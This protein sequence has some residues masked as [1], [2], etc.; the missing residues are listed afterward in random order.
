MGNKKFIL[1]ADNFGVNN[2]IN[3]GVLD[4]YNAGLIT[5]AGICAN[6]KEFDAAV[7][8]I[9]PECPHLG[10]CAN[11][12]ISFGN[13]I[14]NC[15]FIADGRRK[16]NNT[17]AS[18]YSMS[19][20]KKGI[21]AIEKEF[22][23]QIEKISEIKKIDALNSNGNVHAIPRIFNIVCKL[24]SEY[25]IPFVRLSREEIIIPHEFGKVTKLRFSVNLIKT[26]I[27]N[28]FS[29]ENLKTAEKYGIKTNNLTIGTL[30]R[31]FLEPQLVEEYLNNIQGDCIVECFVIPDKVNRKKEYNLCQ[32]KLLADKIFRCGFDLTNYRNLNEK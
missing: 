2:G 19:A 17:Y 16:F 32:N 9:L 7:N 3:R 12:N 29:K 24:A 23:A 4:G 18:I 15:D 22:R 20:N 25:N 8:E 10:I 1:N 21:I 30:Y 26:L 14:S 6:G 13:A 27:T 5:S 28:S 31:G 11:L